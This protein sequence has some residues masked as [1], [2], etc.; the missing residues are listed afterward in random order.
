MS[1]HIP[2]SSTSSRSRLLNLQEPLTQSQLSEPLIALLEGGMSAGCCNAYIRGINSYLTWLDEKELFTGLK[3]KKL[4]TN[5]RVFKTLSD[6]QLKAIISFK[7]QTF[8]EHR[9]YTLLCLAI[10]TGCRIDELLVLTRNNVD[11]TILFSE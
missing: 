7:P 9:L 4:K 10:D 1:P 2:F 6:Q 5:K 11:S 8:F 3:V